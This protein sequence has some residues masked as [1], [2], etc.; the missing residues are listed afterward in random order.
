VRACAAV[1]VLCVPL[2]KLRAWMLG[3]Y[4]AGMTKGDY[5]F[6]YVSSELMTPN[7]YSQL[8]S[9]SLWQQNNGD[10]VKIKRVMQSMLI[11]SEKVTNVYL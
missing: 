3:A 8:T 5:A 4:N 7:V 11:V 6:I 9:A 1:V 10:D 2:Y